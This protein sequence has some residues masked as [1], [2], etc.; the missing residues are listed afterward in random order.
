MGEQGR[1]N[2]Q[3]TIAQVVWLEAKHRHRDNRGLTVE[4]EDAVT[5]FW[6]NVQYRE[7][8]KVQAKVVPARR[9]KCPSPR[10]VSCFAVDSQ[11]LLRV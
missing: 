9:R 8:S 10:H 1:R 11:V 4:P 7:R 3:N 5:H 2:K 6:R